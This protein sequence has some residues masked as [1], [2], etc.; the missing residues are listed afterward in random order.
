MS[1]PFKSNVGFFAFFSVV[2]SLYLFHFRRYLFFFGKYGIFKLF[3]KSTITFLFDTLAI[4]IT[5]LYYDSYG[6]FCSLNEDK[7]F[8]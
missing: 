3:V 6:R 2:S 5:I 8:A 1:A 7:L 4:A